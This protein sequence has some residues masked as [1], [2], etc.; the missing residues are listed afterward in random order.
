MQI[1]P[2]IVGALS[3]LVGGIF[4]ELPRRWQPPSTRNVTKNGPQRSARDI[5]A[6]D[7]LR[8]LHNERFVSS[9]E[10]L[11]YRRVQTQRRGTAP[12][13]PI[14]PD[15]TFAPPTIIDT[16]DAVIKRIIEISLQPSFDLTNSTMADLSENCDFDAPMPFSQACR[17]DLDNVY[18]TIT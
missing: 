3:A 2:A 4:L 5:K 6:G 7:R 1:N 15:E 14:E 9:A 18:R 11:R 12:N 16:A 10:G 17:V 13:R 8:R